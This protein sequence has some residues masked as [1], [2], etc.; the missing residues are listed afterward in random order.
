[1][2]EDTI[3]VS[4]ATNRGYFTEGSFIDCS[5]VIGSEVFPPDFYRGS[6]SARWNNQIWVKDK[7]GMIR[8]QLRVD[9]TL[10]VGSMLGRLFTS[11]DENRR[12]GNTLKPNTRHETQMYILYCDSLHACKTAR[13]ICLAKR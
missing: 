2:G 11:L 8:L 9:F 6:S 12:A 5:T 10:Q 1:M 13:N 7:E 3:E 4:Y